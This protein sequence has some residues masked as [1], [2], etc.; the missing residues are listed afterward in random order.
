MDEINIITLI[1]SIIIAIA[2]VALA[3]FTWR[4]VNFTRKLAEETNKLVTETRRMVDEMT[5]PDV[6]VFFINERPD[7]NPNIYFKVCFCVQNVGMHT[8]RKVRFEGDL[9]FKPQDKAIDDIRWVKNRI[10]VL[11]PMELHSESI[12]VANYPKQHSEFYDISDSKANIKVIFEDIFRREY[13]IDHPL[14]LHEID[15]SKK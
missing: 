7:S 15:V 1:S 4:Y 12:Y 5:R 2:T 10:E 13:S 3:I 11:R 6:V 14:D 8:V 9:T